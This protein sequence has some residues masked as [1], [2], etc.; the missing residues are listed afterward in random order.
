M[1]IAA[2]LHVKIE[3]KYKKNLAQNIY[4]QLMTCLLT[5]P[6]LPLHFYFD[7]S[8]RLFYQ[9]LISPLICYHLY[10]CWKILLCV[11]QLKKN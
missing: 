5:Y 11:T 3:K 6:L 4:I 2:Q 9:V 10:L 1:S 7:L 8:Y